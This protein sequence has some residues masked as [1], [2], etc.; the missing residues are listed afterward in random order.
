VAQRGAERVGHAEGQ[1]QGQVLG[2]RVTEPIVAK[3]VDGPLEQDRTE[4][5]D[6]ADEQHASSP[7]AL[8][9]SCFVGHPPGDSRE[10]RAP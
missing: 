10:I 2:L 6:E 1:G 8:A 9:C 5:L 7:I 4:A 3:K